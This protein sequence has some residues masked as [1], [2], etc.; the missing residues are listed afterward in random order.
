MLWAS[1][2]LLAMSVLFEDWSLARFTLNSISTVLILGVFCT[3]V[4]FWILFK[5]RNSLGSVAAS[6]QVYLRLPVGIA[7]G[8]FFSMR[9]S[10]CWQFSVLF[11]RFGR[12]R[13]A[14]PR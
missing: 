10:V 9:R 6:S 11:C 1:L 12:Y 2:V 5:V 4:G 7:F 13:H 14:C 8:V 3:G